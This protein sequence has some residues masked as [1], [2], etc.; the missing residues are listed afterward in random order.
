MW[1]LLPGSCSRTKLRSVTAAQRLKAVA[2]VES[3]SWSF[4]IIIIINIIIIIVI[5]IISI[6][7]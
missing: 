1:T 5:I 6:I 3:T 4:I 7:T 2:R